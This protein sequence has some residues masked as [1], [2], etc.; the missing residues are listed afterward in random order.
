MAP[1]AEHLVGY[2]SMFL[3]LGVLALLTVLAVLVRRSLGRKPLDPWTI[4]LGANALAL[5]VL[6]VAAVGRDAGL[7][8]PQP[9]A[10]LAYAMLEDLSAVAFVAGARRQR[11]ARPVPGWLLAALAAAFVLTAFGSLTNGTFI[12]TF[13]VHSAFFALLLAAAV[14][15]LLRGRPGGLGS[16]LL[17]A[18]LTALTIDYAH[19][20]LLTALGVAFPENYLGLESYV[21]AVLD[22]ALGVALVVQSTDAAHVELERRNAELDGAKR[23]L[24]EAAYTDALCGVPNRAAFLERIA[25][26]PAAGVVAMIDLDGLKAI[27][28][29]CGHDAGDKALATTARCLRER[30]GRAGIIYRIGG[31]EFAGIWDG[32][33]PSTVRALLAA[34]ERDLA[35]LAEDAVMPAQISW[36]VAAFDARL[37]FSEAMIAADAQLYDRR[38]LRRA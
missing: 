24:H 29:R 37:P 26:P 33:S 4:G 38:N 30:C 18:A 10:T 1:L 35:V 2:L 6:A 7:F 34:C 5:L 23:A 28:D 20:P 27:N 25:E 9:A 12:D 22:I 8:P 31:D 32:A 19:V 14:A 15:E 13:R 3:Q 16:R 36:G 21:T 11:G 17:I